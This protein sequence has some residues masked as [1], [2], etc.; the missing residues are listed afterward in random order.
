MCVYKNAIVFKL[1]QE[2]MQQQSSFFI[3]K[4]VPSDNL[5]K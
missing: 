3:Y 4:T 5:Q 1:M 2:K